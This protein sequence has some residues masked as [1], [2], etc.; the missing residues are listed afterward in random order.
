MLFLQFSIC[1]LW[2][3]A[4]ASE[5]SAPEPPHSSVFFSFTVS[6]VLWKEKTGIPHTLILTY[7]GYWVFLFLVFPPLSWLEWD[8][9]AVS[10]CVS[11]LCCVYS[12]TEGRNYPSCVSVL[13]PF[14]PGSWK[15]V[16]MFQ[17]LYWNTHLV[18]PPPLW[19][20]KNPW[21]WLCSYRW[22]GCNVCPAMW[23]ALATSAT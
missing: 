20:F 6:V 22:G 19:D 23:T 10:P 15:A 4:A 18:L 17:Q 3:C 8:V 13:Y 5:T 16:G 7:E 11:S 1:P 9:V 2:Q 21:R 12:L 14:Q